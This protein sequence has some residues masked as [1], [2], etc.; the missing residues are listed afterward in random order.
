MSVLSEEIHLLL[1]NK[2][3]ALEVN[4]CLWAAKP[5]PMLLA[6]DLLEI[7]SRCAVC[8][9]YHLQNLMYI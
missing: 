2:E 9:L 5:H 7:K 1:L 6:Q 3:S 8:L 4:V